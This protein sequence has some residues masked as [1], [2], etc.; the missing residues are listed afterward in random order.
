[1]FMSAALPG[2]TL[3]RLLDF[4]KEDQGLNHLV[5]FMQPDVPET[6]IDGQERYYLTQFLGSKAVTRTDAIDR[7]V[8]AYSRPG[9]LEAT[10]NQYRALYEDARDN[11][12]GAMPKLT[13]PVLTLDA[14]APGL[15]LESM[16]P[17]AENVEGAG[18]GGAGHL[19]QEDQPEKV[20][21]RLLDFLD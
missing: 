15:S 2:F 4:R 11:R 19:L 18:I 12:E 14:G 10:F 16:Q 9:R 17:V 7:Y 13:M 6:L 1:V 21:D 8:R 5:F 3:D 20:A